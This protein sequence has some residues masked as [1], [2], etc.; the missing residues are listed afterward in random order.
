[1][2]QIIIQIIIYE[3]NY[4]Y[5]YIFFNI[6]IKKNNIFVFNYFEIFKLCRF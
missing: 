3:N 6:F 4:F 2:N 5:N 1:M